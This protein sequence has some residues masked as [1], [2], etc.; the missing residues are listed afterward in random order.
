MLDYVI[1]THSDTLASKAD[2]QYAL[3]DGELTVKAIANPECQVSSIS[4][5]A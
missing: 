1:V 2:H 3:F 5:S 4:Q